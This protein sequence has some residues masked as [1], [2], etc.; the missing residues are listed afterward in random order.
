MNNIILNTEL[1]SMVGVYDGEAL[2]YNELLPIDE[3]AELIAE[4]IPIKNVK[5]S[6]IP[7][8]TTANMLPRY[9]EKFGKT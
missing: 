1:K 6:P 7:H 4:M 2:P 8:S 9:I 5:I 3:K